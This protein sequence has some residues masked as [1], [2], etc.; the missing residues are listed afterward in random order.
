MPVS[1]SVGSR[2]PGYCL[3]GFCVEAFVLAATASVADLWHGKSFCLFLV[4]NIHICPSLFFS[5]VQM[6]KS[7]L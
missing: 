3:S 1:I 5:P 7:Q 4:V 6:L 2:W